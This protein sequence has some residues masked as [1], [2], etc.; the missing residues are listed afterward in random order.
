MHPGASDDSGSHHLLQ[1]MNIVPPTS[2]PPDG[3]HALVE[4]EGIQLPVHYRAGSTDTLI[5]LFHGAVDQKVRPKPHFQPHFP[6]VFG[7]H[8]LAVSDVSLNRS[9]ELKLCW[10]LGTDD[11]PLPR[12][13]TRYFQLVTRI[14]KFKRVIYFGASGG[15]HAALYHSFH[16]PGSLALAVNPQINLSLFHPSE[17]FDDYRHHCWPTV[18]GTEQLRALVPSDLTSVYSSP[19]S[20]FVCILNSS[21]DRQHVFEHTIA[22]MACIPKESQNRMVFHADYFGVRG[23]AVSVPYKSCVPWIK[24]S[25]YAPNLFADS[26]LK[27]LH[28]FR[29]PGATA[30]KADNGSPAQNGRISDEDLRVTEALRAYQLGEQA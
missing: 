17:W 30:R 22:L 1:S 2:L 9:D 29:N 21:G 11:V 19:M 16:H 5:V 14:G 28:Q 24:A 15:G 13:L 18:E 3:E 23:H 8:Q 6:H 7:A 25:V 27:K 20:N 12:L 26:I 4:L 10:F